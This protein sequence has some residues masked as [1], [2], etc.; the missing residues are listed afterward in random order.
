M[1]AAP[2]PITGV[3]V[4]GLVVGM[5]EPSVSSRYGHV[6]SSLAHPPPS[7]HMAVLFWAEVFGEVSLCV[8][9]FLDGSMTKMTDTTHIMSVPTVLVS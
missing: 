4:F 2:R 6:N 1:A 3:R 7:P 8:N 9:S 5:S